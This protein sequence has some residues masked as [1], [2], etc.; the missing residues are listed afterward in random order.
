MD[1]VHEVFMIFISF[2]LM[3]LWFYLKKA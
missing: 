3:F 1:E 2:L